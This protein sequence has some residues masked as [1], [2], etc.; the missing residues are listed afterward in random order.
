MPNIITD[1]TMEI[2]IGVADSKIS[3]IVTGQSYNPEIY[4][5]LMV[6]TMKAYD[7]ALTI[8]IKHGYAFTTTD[9]LI[10]DDDEED[11][12]TDDNN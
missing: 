10:D 6:N 2:H 7:N 3:S 12:D 5:D 8:A 4:N 9:D 11:A 1:Q